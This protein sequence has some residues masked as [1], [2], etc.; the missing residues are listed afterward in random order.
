MTPIQFQNYLKKKK[1]YLHFKD[2]TIFSAFINKDQFEPIWGE[3]A[4]TT[5]M[6]GYQ[7]TMTDPSFLGQHIIFTSAHIGNYPS[8]ENCAQSSRVHGTSIIARNFSAF[9]GIHGVGFDM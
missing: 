9:P 6:S 4:F 5:G 8:N 3:A 7:E 2:G 1:A